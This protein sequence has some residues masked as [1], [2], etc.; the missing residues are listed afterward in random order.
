M[1]SEEQAELPKGHLRGAL[2]VAGCPRRPSVAFQGRKTSVVRTVRTDPATAPHLV[3]EQPEGTRC[4][5]IFSGSSL[6]S[7]TNRPLR[8]QILRTGTPQWRLKQPAWECE[9]SRRK[10]WSSAWTW[11]WTTATAICTRCDTIWTLWLIPTLNFTSTSGSSFSLCCE[12]VF[13]REFLI[14]LWGVVFWGRFSRWR[15]SKSWLYSDGEIE[16]SCFGASSAA[17]EISPFFAL[18]LNWVG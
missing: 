1:H 5:L 4:S 8:L 18:M 9:R 3:H 12:A 7:K 13:S 6:N 17:K 10:S 11:C 14:F 2:A 16:I 15:N